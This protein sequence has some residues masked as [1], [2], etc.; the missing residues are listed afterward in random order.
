M[1]EG[2]ASLRTSGYSTLAIL[3]SGSESCQAAGKKGE[4]FPPFG[5]NGRPQQGPDN[6][7]APDTPLRHVA[8]DWRSN[9]QGAD[10]SAWQIGPRRAAA[11][12][13]GST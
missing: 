4:N 1:P 12:W 5:R 6:D 9:Q 3:C 2:P 7:A 8:T 11:Q 13:S 10:L